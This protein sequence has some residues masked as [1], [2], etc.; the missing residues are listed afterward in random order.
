MKIINRVPID[1]D[2]S[3]WNSDI[4]F[5]H[6]MLTVFSMNYCRMLLHRISYGPFSFCWS[7]N[8]HISFSWL[9]PLHFK[10]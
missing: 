9:Q 2:R 7:S 8:T 5:G 4:V 3:V 6:C 1:T 10:K